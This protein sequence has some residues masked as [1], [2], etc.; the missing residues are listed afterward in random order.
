ML[1]IFEKYGGDDVFINIKYMILIYEFV[2]L[3]QFVLFFMKI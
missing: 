2:V 3:F 1:E